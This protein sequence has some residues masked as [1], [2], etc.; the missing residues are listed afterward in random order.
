[1]GGQ[2]KKN[3]P[4][5]ATLDETTRACT[6]EVIDGEPKKLINVEGIVHDK[7]D[8]T[9]ENVNEVTFETEDDPLAILTMLNDFVFVDV[10]TP[11]GASNAAAASNGRTNI[12]GPGAQ[13][14][15][16]VNDKQT[17]VQILGKH[18]K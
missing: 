16:W 13:F 14:N 15:I 2:F 3:F 12:G 8:G 10:S 11:Q 1:M 4:G 9:S 17:P 6:D 7:E 18:T 5:T